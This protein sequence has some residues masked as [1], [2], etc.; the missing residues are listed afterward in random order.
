MKKFEL[1]V[2]G[3]PLELRAGPGECEAEGVRST[4]DVAAV[5]QG[6]YSV[7]IDG[8]QHLVSITRG[9]QGC[10][11]ARVAGATLEIRVADPRRLPRDGAGADSGGGREVRA[12]MPGRIVAVHVAQGDAVTNGQGLLV[13]EA[14]KMQ[15]ELRAPSEGRVR[16][17][18]V[19][20]G[21]SVGAGDLLIGIE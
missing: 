4:T 5:G 19:R 13:I 11:T 1:S 12:P 9:P 18:A 8:R 15:N 16:S 10:L 14:M 20:A 7:L 2:D 17:V 3:Q 21:D 6:Q